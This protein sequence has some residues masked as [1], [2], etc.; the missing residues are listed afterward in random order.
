MQ[1]K[2]VDD[3]WISSIH[4]ENCSVPLNSSQLWYGFFRLQKL[5]L[6]MLHKLLLLRIPQAKKP[7][8]THNFTSQMQK[9]CTHS[10]YF[11][12]NKGCSASGEILERIQV[13]VFNTLTQQFL[14]S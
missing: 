5:L 6:D 13:I 10:S 4:E 1:S 12:H 8:L 9:S 2:H 7:P 3:S 14:N 11:A